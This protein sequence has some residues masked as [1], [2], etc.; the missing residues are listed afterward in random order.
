MTKLLLR[1]FSYLAPRMVGYDELIVRPICGAA[2]PDGA[3]IDTSQRE[4]VGNRI[5]ERECVLG[6]NFHYS[7]VDS[8]VIVKH[9][10]QR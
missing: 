8:S 5:E 6:L 3:D 9:Q 7:S 2:D 1:T 10:C 4:C